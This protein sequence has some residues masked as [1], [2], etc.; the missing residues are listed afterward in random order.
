MFPPTRTF[1]H[2][3]IMSPTM[4]PSIRG[5]KSATPSEQYFECFFFFFLHQKVLL[6]RNV[7]VA[8]NMFSTML[9][10][11]A[12]HVEPTNIFSVPWATPPMSLGFSQSHCPRNPRGQSLRKQKRAA[13]V[14]ITGTLGETNIDVGNH[15]F[16]IDDLSNIYVSLQE[17]IVSWLVW[18]LVVHHFRH[19]PKQSN[20]PFLCKTMPQHA[21][22]SGAAFK[23]DPFKWTSRAEVQTKHW[24]LQTHMVGIVAL[25]LRPATT[26]LWN[27]SVMN[28][29][30][31]SLPHHFITSERAMQLFG[32]ASGFQMAFGFQISS[33]LSLFIIVPFSVLDGFRV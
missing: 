22:T 26:T 24:E 20:L 12:E 23:I 1:V 6:R 19:E 9:K 4:T 10:H 7:R 8:A 32:W 25:W 29:T 21:R 17:G 3:P 33:V 14:T 11:G 5:C 31:G 18:F 16:I 2:L 28:L 13:C 30:A 27:V 15:P